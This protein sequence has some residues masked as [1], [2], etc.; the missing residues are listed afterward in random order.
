VPRGW[1]VATVSRLVEETARAKTIVLDVPGWAGHV[2]GQN[3]DVRLT[4]EDGYQAERSYA[5]ASAPESAKVA[6]TVERIDDGEVSSHLTGALRVADE[7]ELRGP[8]GGPITWRVDDGGPLLLVADGTGLVPLM[9]MLRHRAAKSSTVDARLLISTG[10]AAEVLYRSEL[11]RLAAGH[12]RAIHHTFTRD[13]PAAWTGFARRLDADMLNAVGPPP[14]NVHGSSSPARRRSSA[15]RPTYSSSLVTSRTGSGSRTSG[16]W[17]AEPP[18]R[19]QLTPGR[20]APFAA[21][22][23]NDRRV[24]RER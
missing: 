14:H 17:E 18:P 4:A 19:P 22:T 8:I 7:L 24:A 10:S 9:A 23:P 3:V 2:A 15:E 1:Q 11:M 13:P 20:C 12:G 21:L 16:R 5:I 6:L